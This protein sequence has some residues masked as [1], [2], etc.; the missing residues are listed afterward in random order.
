MPINITLPNG[1]RVDVETPSGANYFITYPGG[2]FTFFSGNISTVQ[3]VCDRVHRRRPP[4]ATSQEIDQMAVVYGTAAALAKNASPEVFAKIPTSEIQCYMEHVA[5]AL[6]KMT[7]AGATWSRTGNLTQLHEQILL[8]GLIELFMHSAPCKFAFDMD[9][10]GVMAKFASTPNHVS[11][12]PAETITMLVA[13]TIISTLIHKDDLPSTAK[14]F[15]KLESCGMLKQFIPLSIVSPTS[16]PGVLKFYD[17]LIECRSL[18]RKRFTEDQPCGKVC[19]EI[20]DKASKTSLRNQHPVVT[21]LKTI[22][23]FT[24]FIEKDSESKAELKDG[25]K[26]CRKCNKMEHSMEFQK[27]LMKVSNCVVA[28]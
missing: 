4:I 27:G 17:L 7:E 18:T 28:M 13:N 21:K 12:D 20:L 25:Y 2:P 11:T 19:R 26:N 14:A 15:E 22:M 6:T 24:S 8:A 16:S 10:F 23:S 9:F 3:A 1:R 5:S